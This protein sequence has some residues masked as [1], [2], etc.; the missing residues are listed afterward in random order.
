MG[1]FR[2]EQGIAM[3]EELLKALHDMA[4]ALADVL[5]DLRLLIGTLEAP[6]EPATGCEN[7]DRVQ[8]QLGDRTSLCPHHQR[9]YEKGM[10]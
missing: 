4:I 10:I 9:E 7:C 6:D 2:Y 1:R 8:Q 3:N 5:S